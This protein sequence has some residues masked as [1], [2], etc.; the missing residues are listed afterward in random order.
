MSEIETKLAQIA[1]AFE[2]L[3]A[4]QDSVIA[5]EVKGRTADVV[6]KEEV[7]RINA[8]IGELNDEVK[9]LR[10]AALLG[11]AGAGVNPEAKA[12]ADQFKS[13][14]RTG[15]GEMELRDMERKA[16]TST[17][18]SSGGFAVPE[19]IDQA[20]LDQAKLISPVRALARSIVVSTPDYKQLVNT[21]GMASGWVAETAA[22]TET[23]TPAF[24]EV[25]AVMGEIYANPAATQQNLDDVFFDLEGFIAREVAAEFAQKEAQAFITG[26]GTAKPKGFTTYTTNTSADGTRTFGHLQ[27]VLTG[28]AG[29]FVAVTTSTSPADTFI[30]VVHAT[31]GENRAG[32]AWMVGRLTL[33]SIRK[34]KTTDGDYIWRPGLAEGQPDMLL[35]YPV[36]E[37]EDMPAVAT[38]TLPIAFGNW[39]RGYTIVD[40]GSTRMLRDPFSNK[41]YIHFYSTKRVGGM[42]VDSD[43]IKFLATRT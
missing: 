28:V 4:K 13:W 5:A 19:L 12:Y 23:N 32:A 21:R 14:A 26:D 18:G 10:R 29:G 2:E 34:F 42:V 40:V 30:D 41:P 36:Y 38:N 39:Q 37:V 31:R 43:A 1:S 27:M 8:S 6:R 20:I 35:G 17:T 7:D 9:T 24:Q 16:F 25:A 33:A 3:K 15:N 11:G 22:R